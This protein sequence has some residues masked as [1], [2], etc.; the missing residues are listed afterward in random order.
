MAVGSWQL[1]L[2]MAGEVGQLLLLLFVD[3]GWFG[4][5]FC[6]HFVFFLGVHVDRMVER[7]KK[8]THTHTFIRKG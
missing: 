3:G 7:F 8:K 6:V 4:F 1:L 5:F 2:L